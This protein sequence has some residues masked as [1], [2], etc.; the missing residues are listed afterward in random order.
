M[1]TQVFFGSKT[2][3]FGVQWHAQGKNSP[4]AI[5]LIKKRLTQRCGGSHFDISMG[6]L[7]VKKKKKETKIKRNGTKEREKM[8]NTE[9]YWISYHRRSFN[10]WPTMMM[11]AN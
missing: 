7:N 6:A 3:H 5:K 9:L 2:I 4:A 10:R 11:H 8:T 1:R